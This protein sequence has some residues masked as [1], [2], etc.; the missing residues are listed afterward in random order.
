M[1]IRIDDLDPTALPSRDHVF[2]AVK[3]GVTVKLSVGQVLDILVA[4]APGQLDTL[5][6]LA[7]ALGDDPNFAATITAAL[8]QKASL[9]GVEALTNKTLAGPVINAPVGEFLRGHIRGLTLSNNTTDAT[10]DIDIAAGSAASDGTTPVLMTLAAAITKRLDAG[11]A[12]GSGNGGLDTGTITN[13]TYHL[14]VIQ[15]SD[16][17]VVD[18]LFSTSATAPTM[19]ANYDR[20]RRIGSIMRVSASIRA[21]VQDGDDFNWVTPDAEVAATNPGT[22]AVLRT[23]SVPLGL[24]V[25]AT[26]NVVVRH[27]TASGTWIAY[28]SDPLTADLA[29]GMTATPLSNA[30]TGGID[31]RHGQQVHVKTNTSGQVRTRLA[32]TDAN[33]FLYMATTGWTDFRGRLS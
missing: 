13:G 33:L 30:G 2:A 10:N 3:D 26:I 23:I 21:F 27:S 17:G 24:R 31:H 28:I 6:E 16:T 9:T 20:K 15:R 1:G 32:S 18:A 12:V 29:P 7:D 5:K 8:A 4:A 19:P 14:W 11:W 25:A 22:S